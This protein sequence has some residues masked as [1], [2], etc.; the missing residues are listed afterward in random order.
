[1]KI[2][3]IITL[4][5]LSCSILEYKE[6]VDNVRFDRLVNTIKSE[7]TNDWLESLLPSIA[8][9]VHEQVL[10][11]EIELNRKLLQDSRDIVKGILKRELIF[12]AH[13]AIYHTDGNSVNVFFDKLELLNHL[14]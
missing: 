3:K 6:K 13:I 11:I 5:E 10:E 1:M 4:E 9:S 2:A 14:K 7:H 8:H 12:D